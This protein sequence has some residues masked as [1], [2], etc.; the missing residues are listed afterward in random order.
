MVITYGIP[1]VSEANR[2]M[3]GR[4]SSSDDDSDNYQ[5]QEAQNLDGCGDYFGFTEKLDV[6]QIDGQDRG[7]TNC[8]D[9]GGSEI[10]PVRYHY[11][12]SGN[13]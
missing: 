5:A 10:C 3:I 6:Q 13:F 4:A 1:P 8:N 12:C 9:D 7:E 11:C 2:L